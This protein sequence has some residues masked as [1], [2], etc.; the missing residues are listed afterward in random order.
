MT[1]IVKIARQGQASYG[2]A[3]GQFNTQQ[4]MGMTGANQALGLA[5]GLQQ[6][7]QNDVQQLMG[8]GGM[9][10]GINQQ[11]LDLGYQDFQ[12]QQY[13]PYEQIGFQS[14]ILRGTPTPGL[15]PTN[16]NQQQP[17]PNPWAQAAGL[18]IAAYGAYNMFK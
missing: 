18:G 13:F 9:Q 17:D 15:Q 2:Q 16:I 10:Q 4:Q 11:N 6:A 7:G 1:D 8:T 14:G 3:L 5:G 12:R